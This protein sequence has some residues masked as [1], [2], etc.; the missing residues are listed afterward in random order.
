MDILRRNTD[1][2]LRMMGN[3]A[4][5]YDQGSVSVKMLARDE[6]VSYQF[7]CKILQQLHGAGLVASVM[8]PNGG[9][10]L[11]REPGKITMLE[12]VKA[13]QKEVRV[14]RCTAGR[15]CC[16]RETSCLVRNKLSQLQQQV[17]DFLGAVTL[18]D[19][20]ADGGAEVQDSRKSRRFAG[21]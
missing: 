17:H 13:V 3:L 14:N 21:H 2:A 15:G 4:G 10:R 20:Q 6:S 9:Y 8:G 1:Y 16:P 18:E 7:A 19:L 5:H 12:V 11:G